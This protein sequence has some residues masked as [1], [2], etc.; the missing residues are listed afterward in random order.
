MALCFASDKVRKGCVV[1]EESKRIG[2]VEG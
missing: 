2:K 1:V